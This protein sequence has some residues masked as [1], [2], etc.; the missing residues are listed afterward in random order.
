MQPLAFLLAG[1][2]PLALA[3][4]SAIAPQRRD[5]DEAPCDADSD[6]CRDIMMAETCFASVVFSRDPVAMLEC[7][8]IGNPE[9]SK[10]AVSDLDIDRLVLPR[11]RSRVG[12]RSLPHS[13]GV[14]SCANEADADG[15]CVPGQMCACYGCTEKVLQDFA[16]ENYGC[17][18]TPAATQPSLPATP[19]VPDTTMPE[20]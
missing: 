18:A 12:W 14:A 2:L 8:Y 10:E 16:I 4:P 20:A 17:A 7:I 3:L 1:S 5:E 6:I 13:L 11:S 15:Q 9:K 19:A